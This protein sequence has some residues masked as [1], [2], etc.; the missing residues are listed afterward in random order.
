M[1]GA[2]FGEIGVLLFV[3][4]AAFREI[5][6]DS[7]SAKCCSF[8]YKL[9]LQDATSKVSEARVQNN[10][11]IFGLC[12]NYPGIIFLLAAA[13]QRVSAEILKE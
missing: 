13:I 11:F 3:A 7:R 2:I 5:L 1:A 6:E 9:R 10:D 8:P 4:G 12:S